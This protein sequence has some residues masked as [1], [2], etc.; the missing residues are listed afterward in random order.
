ME[1]NENCVLSKVTGKIRIE[2]SY[3][4][5][6]KYIGRPIKKFRCVHFSNLKL[7]IGCEPAHGE[8]NL[9]KISRHY[10]APSQPPLKVLND[11]LVPTY[12]YF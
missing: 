1:Y 9:M 11:L 5:N 8:L 6:K 3:E 12:L 4:Q 7:C 2:F 10:S